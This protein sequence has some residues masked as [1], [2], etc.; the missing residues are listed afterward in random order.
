MRIAAFDLS[1]CSTGYAVLVDTLPLHSG[2]LVPTPMG[3]IQR[4]DWIVCQVGEL[5]RGSD[6]VVVE[7]FAFTRANQAHQLGGLGYMVRHWLWKHDQKY[8]DVG[9]SA[10]KKFVTG[11]GNVEKNLMLK[12]AYKRFGLDVQDD[13]E[14]DACC[15]AILGAHYLGLREPT[16]N[17]Q[18]E[19]LADLRSEKP[20]K[21]RKRAA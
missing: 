2:V 17:Q 5:A 1:L 12:E 21:K 8:L 16:I 19:V 20:A 6:L 13:N 15:L 3:E 14:C 9:P 11:K 18:R 10:L 7:G 4:L